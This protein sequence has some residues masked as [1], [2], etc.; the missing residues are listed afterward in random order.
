MIC[1]PLNPLQFFQELS[2]NKLAKKSWLLNFYLFS[3][4]FLHSIHY[5][6]KHYYSISLHNSIQYRHWQIQWWQMTLNLLFRSRYCHRLCM[7]IES[8]EEATVDFSFIFSNRQIFSNYNDDKGRGECNFIFTLV[9]NTLIPPSFTYQ[10][11][12]FFLHSE[13]NKHN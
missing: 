9:F 4:Q 7:V 11:V 8:S 10:S 1:L 6:R 13:L 3:F 2:R 5:C 12:N